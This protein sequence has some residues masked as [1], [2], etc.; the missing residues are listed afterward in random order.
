VE[1]AGMVP[2]HGLEELHEGTGRG[3]TCVVLSVKRG[4][5]PAAGLFTKCGFVEIPQPSGMPYE[6]NADN[7][8]YAYEL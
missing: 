6:P 1:V 2:D 3:R 4:N 8:F 5:E 7:R